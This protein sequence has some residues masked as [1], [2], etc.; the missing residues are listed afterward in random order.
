MDTA[1]A[2]LFET[3]RERK[4]EKTLP[5]VVLFCTFKTVLLSRTEKKS[6]EKIPADHL[7]DGRTL[8]SSKMSFC[9]IFRTNSYK[10]FQYKIADY[11]KEG[12]L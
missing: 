4:S 12:E 7:P 2:A 5:S 11:R 1:N 10:S 9:K 6:K 8:S 3:K